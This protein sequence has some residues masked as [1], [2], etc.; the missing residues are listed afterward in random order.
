MPLRIG[1][2]NLPRL[3]SAPMMLGFTSLSITGYVHMPPWS[4][5]Y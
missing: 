1:S 3:M 5:L 4:H 2:G